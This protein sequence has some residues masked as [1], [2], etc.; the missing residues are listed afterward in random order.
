VTEIPTRYAT[1]KAAGLCRC[2]R[3]LLPG[4][5]QCQTC[6]ARNAENI[7][8]LRAKR[9]AAGECRRCGAQVPGSQTL[10]D[11]HLAYMRTKEREYY[12]A[13]KANGETP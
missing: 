11:L 6:K 1:F 3:P 12:W 13:K 4:R 7:R 5:S 9:K 10:C 2:R 8:V